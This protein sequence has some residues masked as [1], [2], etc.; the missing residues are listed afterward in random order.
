MIDSKV[1]LDLEG[2]DMEFFSKVY[3]ADKYFT[4]KDGKDYMRAL[5]AFANSTTIAMIFETDEERQFYQ[6]D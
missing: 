3:Y 1:V 5:K 6:E 2:R 4:P